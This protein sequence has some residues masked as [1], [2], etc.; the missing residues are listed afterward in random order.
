MIQRIQQRREEE[1]FT[2]IEL[3][4]VIIV[5]AILAAI[6]VFALGSTRSDSVTSACKSSYKSVE[7]SAESVHTKIGLYPD[8]N[9][10]LGLSKPLYWLLLAENTAGPNNRTNGA[11]LKTWPRSSDYG[12]IY[13][14]AP[15]GK[16]YTLLVLD[17]KA[18]RVVGV[19]A[20]RPLDATA[21]DCESLP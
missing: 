17:V 19:G 4:I 10:S 11:L 21:D 15:D 5:L 13:R 20:T 2:L 9:R 3:L 16:S 1:G 8:A 12:L 7:L 14:A 18:R 6:V